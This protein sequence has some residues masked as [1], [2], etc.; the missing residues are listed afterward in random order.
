VTATAPEVDDLTIP[1][2]PAALEETLRDPKKMKAIF[3]QE[4]K[5]AEFIRAYAKAVHNQDQS[6]ATQVRDQ[7]QKEL[8]AWLREKGEEEGI[9]PVNLGFTNPS[10]VRDRATARGGLHN[11]KA[12]GAPLDKEFENSA[13]YF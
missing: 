1:D 13:D 3:A 7:V 8:G 12:M 2:S 5:F 4:G 11:P 9:A 6:I 10:F